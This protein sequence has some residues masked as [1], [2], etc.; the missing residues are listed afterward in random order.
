MNDYTYFKKEQLLVWN[1]GYIKA[2]TSENVQEIVG[3]LQENT[4]NF[5]TFA[6]VHP[7]EIQTKFFYESTSHRFNRIFF[8]K[9]SN[10]P[11]PECENVYVVTDP[12]WTMMK[13]FT[14]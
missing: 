13:W 9:T 1:A 10:I 12:T 7:S 8:V 6:K 3:S 5:A 11:D 2:D 14:N 4:L